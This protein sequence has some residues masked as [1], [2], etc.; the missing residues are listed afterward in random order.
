M[1]ALFPQMCISCGK[2][3]HFHFF[4]GFGK[5][6][7]AGTF[8]SPLSSRAARLRIT[9]PRIAAMRQRGIVADWGAWGK[10]KVCEG[11]HRRSHLM[12]SFSTSTKI[13]QLRS[14]TRIFA[15]I[16]NIFLYAP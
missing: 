13:V 1:P 4:S 5:S 12:H 8:A 2:Q 3:D 10:R 16:F 6:A 15:P 7:R 11:M 14:R 9:G